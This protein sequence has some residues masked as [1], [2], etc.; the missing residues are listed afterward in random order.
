[1][2]NYLDPGKDHILLSLIWDQ[3]IL[4]SLPAE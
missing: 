3:T 1:M 2:S 4:Q